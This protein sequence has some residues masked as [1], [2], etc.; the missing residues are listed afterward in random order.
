M[1]ILR[2][3]D[4]V[5]ALIILAV[6]VHVQEV[7]VNYWQFVLGCLD[8]MLLA[9]AFSF[10]LF[11]RAILTPC[12]KGQICFYTVLSLLVVLYSPINAFGFIAS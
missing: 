6:D 2:R 9:V 12:A 11:S 4:R 8:V 5:L 1:S 3:H 10:R 7:D